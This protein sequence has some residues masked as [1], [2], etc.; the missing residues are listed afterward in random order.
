MHNPL[1]ITNQALHGLNIMH[2]VHI[3]CLSILNE[4]DNISNSPNH[5]CS[6]LGNVFV[7]NLAV[8]KGFGEILEQIVDFGHVFL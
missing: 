2:R 7:C 6:A 1:N 8:L 4:I 3:L 5:R